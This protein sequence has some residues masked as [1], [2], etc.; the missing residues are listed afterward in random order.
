M[1]QLPWTTA[2]RN[3]T[4]WPRNSIPRHIHK[5]IENMCPEIS[6]VGQ[7]KESA[8]QCKGCEFDPWLGNSD[9]TCSR[10]TKPTCRDYWGYTPQLESTCTTMER[11]HMTQWRCPVPQLRPDVAK[12][13]SRK[14][15]TRVPTC[16]TQE[17]CTC[18]QRSIK[19]ISRKVV[20][21]QVLINS[22]R[23]KEN[24]VYLHYG[25]VTQYSWKLQCGYNL[26]TSC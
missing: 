21:I 15:W 9:P 8:L 2:A 26:K 4:I 10:T 16:H 20:T 12:W 1:I 22:L 11:P 25:I 3:V 19:H 14:K 5:T 18:V 6:L 13:M 23:D 24:V 7:C 17:T